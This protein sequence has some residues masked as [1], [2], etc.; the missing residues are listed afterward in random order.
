MPKTRSRLVFCLLVL[1]GINTMNFFDRQVPGAV[2][3]PIRREFKLSDEGLGWVNTAFILLYAVVGIPLGRWADVGRRTRILA[4]GVIIWSLLTAVS[5]MAQGF[6]S[7]CAAR[8]GVGIGEASCA[9]AANSLVGD[10]FPR[11][12]RARAISI[13]MLGLPLGLGLSFIISGNVADR[14]GWRAA[15]FVAAVPGILLGLL[16][17][18]VPEPERGAAESRQIGSSCRPGSPLLLV[19]GIP[20]MWWIILSGALHNFNMY[21]IG[22]F[23]SP[24]LERYHHLTTGQAGW[25][26][27]VVYGCF[28]GLGILLGGWACDRLA[29]NR[30]SVRLEIAT[31]AA[32][33]SV[34]CLF[35]ALQ[36]GQGR[37][38]GFAAFLLPGCMLLY[39]YY[40]AVYATIQDIVE[41]ALRGT[42]MGVYFC[43]MYLL[44]GALGPILTGKLSGFL[45][46]RFEEGLGLPPAAELAGA[47]GVHQFLTGFPTMAS[48][49]AIQAAKADYGRSMGLHAAMYLIPTLNVL[50]VVVLFIGSRT[51]KKDYENLHK[52]MQTRA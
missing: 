43:A 22:G 30:P 40:S 38:W 47:F 17:F 7:L 3:E 1:M 34:P 8:L 52:W 27:G 25:I 41:P 4:V 28:G 44:G 24:L 21:A 48:I 18:W 39:M 45:K 16:M 50:L 37:V 36:Q 42:A 14:W 6:W 29:G 31:V 49:P 12:R 13:F 15:F 5:G 9:P 11:E 10:L 20:T 26:S 19:L 32:A 46:S 33:L 35:M 2:G 23:L 51:V